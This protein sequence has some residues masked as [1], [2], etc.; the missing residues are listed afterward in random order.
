[1]AQQAAGN[2]QL[3]AAKQQA[4]LADLAG[5]QKAANKAS[6]AASAAQSNAIGR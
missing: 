4:S 6:N 5:A 2:A 3:L 1:M